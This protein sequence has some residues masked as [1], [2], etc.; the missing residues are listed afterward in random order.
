MI[1]QN[2]K[3]HDYKKELS[4]KDWE[5]LGSKQK[6]YDVLDNSDSKAVKDQEISNNIG[7]KN[8]PVKPEKP[9]KF[10]DQNS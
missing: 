9:K 4:K 8:E 7:K 1:I 2:K 3:N 6:L 10:S 5:K